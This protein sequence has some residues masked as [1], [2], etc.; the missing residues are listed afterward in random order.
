V[1]AACTRNPLICRPPPPVAEAQGPTAPLV[2]RTV[3]KVDAR[4]PKQDG[5]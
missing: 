4:G 2:P 5:D 3:S 1:H